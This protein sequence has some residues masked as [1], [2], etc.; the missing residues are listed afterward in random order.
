MQQKINTLYVLKCLLIIAAVIGLG[1]LAVNQAM[2]F[3]YAGD[4]L[5][6][7]CELCVKLN[8]EWQVCYDEHRTIVNRTKPEFNLSLVEDNIIND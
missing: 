7:P 3:Y 5:A 8:P 6:T 1:T 4:L 2:Q